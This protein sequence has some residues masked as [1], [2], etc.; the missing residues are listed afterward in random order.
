VAETS[1]FI[2]MLEPKARNE[3][4]SQDVIAKRTCAVIWYQQA[5]SHALTYSGKPWKYLLILHDSI[6]E[7]VT[8]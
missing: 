8:H 3:L 4:E 6:A 7:N 1:H 2:Y 5:S